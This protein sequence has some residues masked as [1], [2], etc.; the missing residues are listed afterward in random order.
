MKILLLVLVVIGA[1]FV[2]AGGIWVA[3]ALA[4]VISARRAVPESTSHI[5]KTTDTC[6]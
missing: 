3:I 2:I 1:L 5:S 6:Q 4:N